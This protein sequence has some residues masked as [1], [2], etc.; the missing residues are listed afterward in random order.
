LLLFLF[1]RL[2]TEKKKESMRKRCT[3]RLNILRSL[4]LNRQHA[5]IREERPIHLSVIESMMMHFHYSI[6]CCFLLLN[7][8]WFVFDDDTGFFFII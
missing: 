7:L 8:P 5:I 1:L 4:Y 6:C 2:A 3:H